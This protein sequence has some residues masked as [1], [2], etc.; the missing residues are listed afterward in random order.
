MFYGMHAWPPLDEKET[1]PVLT[2]STRSQRCP[3]TE[4]W[5]VGGMW[6]RSPVPELL[7]CDL[8][9]HLHTNPPVLWPCPHLHVVVLRE[10]S[11]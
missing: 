3:A 1:P 2:P 8:R 11:P 6:S 5:A 9:V 10:G 4:G 7:D